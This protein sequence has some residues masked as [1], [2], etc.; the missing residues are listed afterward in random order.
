MLSHSLRGVDVH[1]L[2]HVDKHVEVG[3]FA[4]AGLLLVALHVV[5]VVLFGE[6]LA[7][8]GNWEVVVLE[9]IVIFAVSRLAIGLLDNEEVRLELSHLAAFFEDSGN[10]FVL[11][12]SAEDHV[13]P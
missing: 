6:S 4:L 8:V 2:S 12:R 11:S 5:L 7:A 9:D 13:L 10:H 1:H 3:E